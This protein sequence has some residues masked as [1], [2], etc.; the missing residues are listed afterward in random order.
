MISL[1]KKI[2]RLLDKLS[3]SPTLPSSR[4]HFTVA[5]SGATDTMLP[6]KSGLISYKKVFELNV[7]MGNNSYIPVLGQGSVVVALNDKCILIRNACHVPSLV[8]PL[9]SLRAHMTQRGCGFF[10]SDKIGFLVYFPTF[11]LLVDTSVNCH[12][13]YKPLGTSAP[14]N[15]F[16]YLQPRCP[17]TLYPSKFAPSLSTGTPSLP[18]PALIEDNEDTVL[19]VVDPA[20]PDPSAPPSV[21]DLGLLLS[22]L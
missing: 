13:S 11:I 21:M 4:G 19:P 14:L 7:R 8:V 10:G 2:M 6:N 15:T 12:L 5:D 1:L 16:H 9:Y 3:L 17:P 22:Q 20:L 18:S